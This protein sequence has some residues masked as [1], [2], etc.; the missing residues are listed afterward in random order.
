[1]IKFLFISL[2]AT[3]LLSDEASADWV[4][5]WVKLNQ[6]PVCFGAKDN[7]YGSFSVST[8]IA[9]T[10]VM[11]V[12]RS[13]WVRCAPSSVTQSNWG[14][15]GDKINVHLT[16][17]NNGRLVPAASVPKD[18]YDFYTMPGYTSKSPVLV[19][20][21]DFS[22]YRNQKLRLW[23]GEDLINNGEGDNSGKSCADVYGLR[24]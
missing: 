18:D 3:V 5:Q 8:N 16:D 23:Y 15:S 1:M 11:L 20:S 22:F 17:Q 6:D 24:G 4:D 21:Q 2:M 14:C 13:G 10:S 12:H 19:F 7:Q 9:V